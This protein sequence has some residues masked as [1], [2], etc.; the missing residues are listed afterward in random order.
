[1]ILRISL[2]ENEPLGVRLN[3]GMVITNI[4][5]GTPANGILNIGDV[6]QTVNGRDI[7]NQRMFYQ[8]LKTAYPVATINIRR[9]G[10][11]EETPAEVRQDIGDNLP[12]EIATSLTRRAGY[13]YKLVEIKR[14]P[15][16]RFGLAIK[17]RDNRVLI[18]EV[19]PGSMCAT[20]L[21]PCDHIIYV[22]GIRVTQA[23]VAQFLLTNKIKQHGLV[24]VVIGRPDSEEAKQ[25]ARQALSREDTHDPPSVRLNTDVQ[26][27]MHKEIIN[28]AAN[29]QEPA[30]ILL[31]P[32][33]PQPSANR[34]VQLGRTVI[35]TIQSD[36][37]GRQLRPVTTGIPNSPARQGQ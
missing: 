12:S 35:T 14:L 9:P 13:H 27:D 23:E 28:R 29:K 7:K 3:D 5:E 10:T 15:K 17:T 22:D 18:T 8:V 19:Q 26:Q 36:N 34:R 6:I 11:R 16:T 4:Q 33:S 21:E 30:S 24:K 37:V 1:M 25:S 31:S 32:G 20:Y 2:E